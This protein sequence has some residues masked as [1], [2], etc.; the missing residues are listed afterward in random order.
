VNM[1]DDKRLIFLH[2]LEGSSQG[3][4]ANLLRGLFPN[5]TTPDFSGALS[6]RMDS[7]YRVV[8]DQTGWTVVGSSFGGLMGAMWTCRRPE[9]VRKLVLLAPALI[10]PD[11]ASAPPAAV[12]V[13]TV[14]Y[15]GTRDA[16]IP[17]EAVR[18]LAEQIFEKLEFY[19]VDDDHGLH[20]TVNAID[21][22]ALVE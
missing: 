14:V 19:V 4:K 18:R 8:G 12:G 3:Y 20:A 6:E 22:R 2:G 15:H 21:W 1:F 9:Q 17:L 11:F 5:L 13:P 7:L 16:I 10:W